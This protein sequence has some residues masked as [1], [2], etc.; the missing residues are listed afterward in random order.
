LSNE[1]VFVSFQELLLEMV[2][3]HKGSDEKKPRRKIAGGAE[4]IT[5]PEV[6]KRLQEK[7]C[8]KP[9]KK[10]KIPENVESESSSDDEVICEDSDDDIDEEFRE[11]RE[12]NEYMDGINEQ[13]RELVVN[14]WVLVVC[15]T[16]KTCKHYIGQVVFLNEVDDEVEVKFTRK[17]RSLDPSASNSF[18]WADPEEKS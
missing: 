1:Q 10:I 9:M 7:Q 11:E 18:I 3:Q 14:D 5:A 12:L 2:K 6:L 15:A 13:Q 4:I 8:K 17:I 16:K